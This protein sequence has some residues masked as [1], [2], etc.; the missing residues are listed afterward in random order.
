MTRVGWVICLTPYGIILF[1]EC[2][3]YYMRNITIENTWLNIVNVD[4]C[5]AQIS[6]TEL[7][8]VGQILKVFP[9]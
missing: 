5:G 3:E 8:A 1:V 2:F 6:I 4:C 7:L 9:I